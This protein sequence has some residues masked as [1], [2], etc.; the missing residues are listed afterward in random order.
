MHG[1]GQA[2]APAECWDFA[3]LEDSKSVPH[4]GHCRSASRVPPVGNASIE[5]N[6]SM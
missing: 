4:T 6:S 3:S 5:I 2:V 1:Q